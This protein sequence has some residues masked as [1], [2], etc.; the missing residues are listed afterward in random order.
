MEHWHDVL[1][2]FIHDVSY[3]N[4]ADDQLGTTRSLL[5]FCGLD[6]DEGCMNFHENERPVKTAS[7][8]QVRQPLYQSSVGLWQHYKTHLEDMI[9]ELEQE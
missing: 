6:W 7:Y 3:E 4:V 2:G 8:A 9:Q 1:P 5:E